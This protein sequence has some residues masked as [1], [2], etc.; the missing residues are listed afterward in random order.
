M[1]GWF[2]EGITNGIRTTRFPRREEHAPG[3]D[4]GAPVDTRM[5]SPREAEALAACCPTGALRAHDTEVVVDASRCV[6]CYRCLRRDGPA[7]NWTDDRVPAAGGRR[8]EAHAPDTGLGAAFRASLQI[9]VVDAG[10]CGACLNEVRQLNNPYY[11]LHRFGFFLTP[12]PRHA[13]LLLVVGPV[14]DAMRHPLL[15][16]WQAMPEPRRVMAVGTCA[17]TGSVFGP[18]FTC[19]TGAKEVLPV[20]IEVPG[21]PP[22]PREILRALLALTAGGGAPRSLPQ[23]A[24][25]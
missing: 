6:L 20:D 24:S 13:D 19:G 25:S 12:T 8:A 4:P 7:M 22:S 10:D 3:V 18:S 17:I 2:L 23:G 16:A 9:L 11:N 15:S 1:R 5:H 14:T 21:S